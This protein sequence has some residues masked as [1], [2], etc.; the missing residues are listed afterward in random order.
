LL[1]ATAVEAERIPEQ[2]WQQRRREILERESD[3]AAKA[4]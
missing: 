3:K 4:L 1:D 2:G